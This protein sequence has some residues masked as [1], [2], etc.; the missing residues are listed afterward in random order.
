MNMYVNSYIRVWWKNDVSEHFG[1]TNGV[2][3]GSVL[4]QI[5]FTLC[6]DDLIA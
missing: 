5:L 6:L 3:Q 2:M 1:A 4:S